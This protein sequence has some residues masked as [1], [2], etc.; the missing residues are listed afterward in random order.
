MFIID[1]YFNNCD[2]EISCDFYYARDCEVDRY[3]GFDVKVAVDLAY[4]FV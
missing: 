2:L 4:V 3:E 1:Q